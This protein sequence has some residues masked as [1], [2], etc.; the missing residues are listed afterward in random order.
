M[1]LRNHIAGLIGLIATIYAGLACDR[2]NPF[3]HGPRPDDVKA[4]NAFIDISDRL[5][6]AGQVR[7]WSGLALFDC[8]NDGDIDIFIANGAD[9]PNRLLRND[10]TAR[11]TEIAEQAGLAMPED[12]CTGCAVADYNNDG[13]L[14][15][16]VARQPIG[17]PDNAPLG[18][19]LM[20]NN[21]AADGDV[22]F[23]VVPAEQ[24]GLLTEVPAFGFGV[25]D[26][27]NDGLL[28][29]L[30]SVHNFSDT[31]VLQDPIY[32]SQPNELWQ[33]T[34]IADGIPQ[35]R[36]ITTAGIEGTEQRGR[37]PDTQNDTFVPGS[38]TLY[39]SDVDEDGRLDF[40]DIHDVP[41]GIDYFHNE[42]N[43]VF[44]RRQIELANTHGGWMGMDGAD[45]DGDGDIDYFVTNVG[46]DFFVATPP[47][48]SITS[49][50][51]PGGTRF[52]RLLRNDNGT[53]VDIAAET[54][55]R[56][57]AVLPPF[58]F[59][60]GRGLQALEF[61]F[62]CTWID[63]D[64]RG[65][66][67]LYWIGDMVANLAP[68]LT[69]DGIGVGIT[70]VP[71]GEG[72]LFDAH[73]V[74]R[75]LTNNGDGSFTDHTAE[76][77]LFNIPADRPIAFGQ[78]EA[79]R[80]VAAAD[81]NGDGYQDLVLTNSTIVGTDPASVR[82]FL[83]PGGD[84]HWLTVRL[85]GI[86]SNRFGLGARVY[87]TVGDRTHIDEVL[88]ATG[89]FCSVHPQAHFGLGQSETVDR[90]EIHWPSGTVTTLTDIDVDQILTV[91]E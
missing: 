22:E 41:G 65:L 70:L 78:N 57:S 51:A 3:P 15:L 58:N 8:D 18:A 86:A 85:I 60:N 69:F 10:G 25:G 75:F 55:V 84:H 50:Q 35:Y 66:P 67:D 45:C 80:A 24:S 44:T 21:G 76:R 37:S 53:L 81:L 52:H 89:A 6:P 73:G 88:C 42:G 14:D 49:V 71:N 16:L 82:A 90:L 4:D 83:N 40:F 32:P 56:H 61:G 72:A 27:D 59:T 1:R 79:G 23:T 26:L 33:C 48:S 20:L 12:H 36:R 54:P 68:A 39:L 46:A 77:G 47:T 5:G 9:T 31:D 30:I 19:A 11:F 29:I 38:F 91:I 7:G 62:G 13:F 34:G 87:A 2:N 28:D 17:V 63:T 43:M 64:N 74:G